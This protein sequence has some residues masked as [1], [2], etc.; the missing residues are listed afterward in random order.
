LLKAKALPDHLKLVVITHGDF[1]HTGNCAELQH[2]YHVKVAMH[3]GDADMVKQGL[4]VK[5]QAKNVLGKLLLLMGRFLGGRFH[6]F[7]PDILLQDRQE[8]TSYGWAARV[9]YTP[10]HTKGSIAILTNDG[11]LFAGDTFTNRGKPDSAQFIESRQDLRAS[12]A[13]LKGLKARVVYPGHGKPFAFEAVASI[14]EP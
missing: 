8:L 4:P 7:Q 12:L 13:V 2:K 14:A 3:P 9:Y 6:R 5:R 11:Q 1:D 10:G